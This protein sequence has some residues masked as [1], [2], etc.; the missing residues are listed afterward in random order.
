MM[1]IRQAVAGHNR[2]SESDS[3]SRSN[4]NTSSSDWDP[5]TE[6]QD[7]TIAQAATPRK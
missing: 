5:D 2:G 7:C 6:G 4:S 1:Q 3:R